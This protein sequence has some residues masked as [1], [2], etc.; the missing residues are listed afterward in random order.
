M[1]KIKAMAVS[2]AFFTLVACG[3]GEYVSTV[4]KGSL[5]ACPDFTV[6]EMFDGFL[7]KTKWQH[8]TE[9]GIDYVNVSGITAGRGKP[10]NIF[11][12][13]WVRNDGFGV[14][15]LKID[16]EAGNNADVLVI[17]RRM[18]APLIEKAKAEQAKEKEAK[19]EEERIKEQKIQE[20]AR[21]EKERMSK[22]RVIL[23]EPLKDPRDGTKYKTVKIGEQTW[24][25]ENLNI[26]MGNS[27]CYGNNPANCKKYGRL[28]NWETAMNA[29]P[30]GWHLPSDDEYGK[31]ERGGKYL[32]AKSGWKNN[33][34]DN[35]GFSALPGGYGNSSGG[36]N[37]VGD[38]GYWWS[39]TEYDA[40]FS[41][42]EF[43]YDN[44][45][46]AGSGSSG[47]TYL[48]SVRC[49]KD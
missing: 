15:A 26:E 20:E 23:A 43:I 3:G 22:V 39:A 13:F 10:E 27:K 16:G 41:Y 5:Q 30:S 44:N 18:C 47:K 45:A 21:K 9:N 2:L 24:M 11:M 19:K 29:C 12:Q 38:S 36:F 48:Y 8:V 37:E 33:G 46:N 31:L 25:A 28:Y 32:K 35:Y 6:G 49:V 14:Q 1:K 42:Y 4:K 7:E 17:L 40:N 34:T